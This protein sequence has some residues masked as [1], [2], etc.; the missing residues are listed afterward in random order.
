MQTALAGLTALARES[1]ARKAAEA[2]T[3]AAEQAAQAAIDKAMDNNRR[4]AILLA[5]IM[6]DE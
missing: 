4:R 1:A 3:I 5:L 2:R 6:A